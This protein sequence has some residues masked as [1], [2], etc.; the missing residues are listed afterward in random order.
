MISEIVIAT[1][2]EADWE[3]WRKNTE[4]GKATFQGSF[5]LWQEIVQQARKEK[6]REGYDVKLV[7]IRLADF[8]AWAERTGNR[9]DSKARAK[10]AGLIADSQ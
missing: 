10:Y 5:Q 1:Y 2:R 3:A 4:D 8:F 9:T 7:E 6:I